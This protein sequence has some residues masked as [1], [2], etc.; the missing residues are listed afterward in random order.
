MESRHVIQTYCLARQTIKDLCHQLE[1]DLMPAISHPNSIS[2]IAQVMSVL[3]FLGTGSFQNTV[4]PTAGISQ[5]MFSL[6][7]KDVLSAL[8]KRLDSYINFPKRGDFAHVKAE[9][10]GLVQIP[11]VVG[12]IDVARVAL[13]PPHDNEQAYQNRKNFQSLNVQIFCLVDLYTSQVCTQYPGSVNDAFIM[14]NSAI[15]QLM[16]KIYLE[17][18]WLTLHTQTV[19]KPTTQG[20]VCFNEAYRRTRQVVKQAFGLLK[21]RFCCIDKSVGTLFYSP[22]KVCQIIVACCMLHNLSL[23]RQIPYITDEGELAVP[24]GEIPGMSSKDDSDVN[25][26]GDMLADLINQ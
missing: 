13:V 4:A 12:S 24:A 9:F 23:R 19:T 20:E 16:T 8:L 6:V 2:P 25:D 22:A 7:L 3:H 15:R 11:H 10:Y 18:A 21:A 17:R 14:W 1:P 26:G 5:P